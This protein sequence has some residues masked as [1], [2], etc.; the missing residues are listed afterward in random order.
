[1]YRDWQAKETYDV[2]RPVAAGG[3]GSALEVQKE[4]KPF[5]LKVCN[6]D[7]PNKK[8]SYDREVKALRRTDNCHVIKP[9]AS[10][11]ERRHLCLV[12]ELA[13]KSLEKVLRQTKR[14]SLDDAKHYARGIVAGLDYLHQK[15]IVHRDIKPNNILLCGVDSQEVKLADFGLAL[16]LGGKRKTILGACG[17]DGYQAPEMSGST[18]YNTQVDVYSFG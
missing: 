2:V 14:L 12:L 17:T 16:W 13:N 1:R 9:H 18:P 6:A 15:A 7:D 3:Y 10:F 11:Q 5:A 4:S 8:E